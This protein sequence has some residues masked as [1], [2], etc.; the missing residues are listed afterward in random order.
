MHINGYCLV[1]LDFFKFEFVLGRDS[2][3]T[4]STNFVLR[5]VVT[6]S[7]RIKSWVTYTLYFV[8]DEVYLPSFENIL[9]YLVSGRINCG[10]SLVSRTH[11]GTPE[12][13]HIRPALVF[14]GSS[15]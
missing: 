7:Q 4:S 8:S 12:R 15:V 10:H 11:D 6:W 2:Y 14:C 5:D 3:F 9:K 1:I 13:D